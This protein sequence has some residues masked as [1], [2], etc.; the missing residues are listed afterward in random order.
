MGLMDYDG[1]IESAN[2]VVEIS[3]FDPTW[4]IENKKLAM[5]WPLLKHEKTKW[6]SREEQY[7]SMT[8][9]RNKEFSFQPFPVDLHMK[10][11]IIFKISKR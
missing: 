6:K 5:A 11:E 2:Q 4:L 7:N 3:L 9:C 8:S 1:S 10:S